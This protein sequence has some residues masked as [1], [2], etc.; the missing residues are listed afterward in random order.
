MDANIAIGLA[1]LTLALAMGSFLAA[2]L[3]AAGEGSESRA[4]APLYRMKAGGPLPQ[5]STGSSAKSLPAS[6][7]YDCMSSFHWAGDW[8]RSCGEA[9][10]TSTRL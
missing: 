5:P 1:I 10:G 3:L 7:Y 4:S 2:A 6:C 8:G 9:C